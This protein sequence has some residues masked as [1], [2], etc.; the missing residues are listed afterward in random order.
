MLKYDTVHGRFPGTVTSD[1]SSIIVNGESVKVN[2]PAEK[3]LELNILRGRLSTRRI[4]PP[5]TGA[6]LVLIMWSRCAATLP[7]SRDGNEGALPL[8]RAQCT[9][10]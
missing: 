3:P 9:V 5:S 2:T 7:P 8:S 10:R 6:A 4:L 1:D